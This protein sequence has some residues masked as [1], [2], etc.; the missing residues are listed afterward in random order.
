[1]GLTN[2]ELCINFTN[3]A[4]EGQANNMF[5]D[6]DKIYSYGRHFV[7]AERIG[8]REF[9]VNTNSYSITTAKHMALFNNAVSCGTVWDVSKCSID[10]IHA[11]T[12]SKLVI[13]LCKI[14][15]ARKNLGKYLKESK[16]VVD[17]YLKF[18]ERFQLKIDTSIFNS[19]GITAIKEKVKE[20][21]IKAEKLLA[22]IISTGF[23]N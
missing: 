13:L 16:E 19:C 20:G 3:G 2:N 9:L 12:E 7:I 8:N 22:R 14:E 21:D 4:K 11:E 5:I 15:K 17:Y 18:C 10:Q 23:I 6:G 1:M